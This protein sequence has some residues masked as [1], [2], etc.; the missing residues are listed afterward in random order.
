M[1]TSAD[2]TRLLLLCAARDIELDGKPPLAVLPCDLDPG[3][4]VRALT[5]FRYDSETST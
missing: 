3:G 1:H 4:R 5:V 2:R